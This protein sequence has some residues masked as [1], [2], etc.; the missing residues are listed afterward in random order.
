MNNHLPN[1]QHGLITGCSKGIGLAVAARMLKTG[2]K[3]TGISRSHS[4]PLLKLQSLYPSRFTFYESNLS[5]DSLS[6]STELSHLLYSHAFDFAIL[7]AGIRSRKSLPLS[8]KDL[9][10][11][12]FDAN[13]LMPILLSK[14][15]ADT[16][17]KNHKPLNIL[18]ISSIVGNLGF[19]ELTTYATSKSA[20]DGFMKSF[21]AEL[22]PFNIRANCLAPGFVKTSYYHNFKTTK[23]ELY[24]WTLD[25]TPLHRWASPMEV[26]KIS[27]FLVSPLNTYMTGTVVFCDGGWSAV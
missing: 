8:D 10:A 5:S 17:I 6:G 15:L 18:F 3:I 21:A 27:E 14:I 11:S 24:Q 23:P 26:A 12:V 16:A 2:Y 9:Y 1:S 20:L 25:R 22:A 19:S 4:K 7:N 13:T